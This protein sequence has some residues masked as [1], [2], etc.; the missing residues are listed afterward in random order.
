MNVAEH[1]FFV[2]VLMKS[3]KCKIVA[4]SAQPLGLNRSQQGLWLLR[5]GHVG[6]REGGTPPRHCPEASGPRGGGAPGRDPG[7]EA[8]P[9]VGEASTTEPLWSRHLWA[10]DERGTGR[11]GEGPQV[12][13]GWAMAMGV[14]EQG[15]GLPSRQEITS[16]GQTTGD[17]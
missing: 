9:R 10:K 4:A 13:N 7:T 15:P 2:S 16:D 1:V 8:S 6:R 5:G 17:P 3:R 11:G 12:Q 14:G